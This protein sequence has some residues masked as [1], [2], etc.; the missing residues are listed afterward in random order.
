MREVVKVV[1]NQVLRK[2]SSYMRVYRESFT[3]KQKNNYFYYFKTQKEEA[4]GQCTSS[5]CKTNPKQC[6]TK[7]KVFGFA[8]F[9]GGEGN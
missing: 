5:I 7:N 3:Q 9:G 4:H 1:Q 8:L 6:F 2:T